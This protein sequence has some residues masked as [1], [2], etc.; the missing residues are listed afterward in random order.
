MR[1]LSIN[2]TENWYPPY[3]FIS[4]YNYDHFNPAPVSLV[5]RQN[6]KWTF[7]VLILTPFFILKRR[8]VIKI[9]KKHRKVNWKCWVRSWKSDFKRKKYQQTEAYQRKKKPHKKTDSQKEQ[10][11]E[12]KKHISKSK[13]KNTPWTNGELR[14]KNRQRRLFML[15]RKNE[16]CDQER[17]EPC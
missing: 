5:A 9:V 13:K 14:R 4:S 12:N 7:L 2:F 17:E 15:E 10:Q 3:P 8:T 16:S 11:N 1:H 6:I